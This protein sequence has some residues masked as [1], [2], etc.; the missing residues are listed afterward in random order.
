MKKNNTFKDNNFAYYIFKGIPLLK[1][2]KEKKIL[3]I[4]KHSNM[5]CFD[6]EELKKLSFFLE[7]CHLYC[8]G[9]IKEI[10]NIEINS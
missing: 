7:S 4:Q 6:Q 8:I 9:V 3:E 2:D 1:F 10:K 5:Y